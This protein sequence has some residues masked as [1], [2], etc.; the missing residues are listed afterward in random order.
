MEKLINDL[1]G[2]FIVIGVISVLIDF[3]KSGLFLIK[4]S[5]NSKLIQRFGQLFQIMLSGIGYLFLVVV[6]H[7][8]FW[9][10]S[11]L[12]NETLPAIVNLIFAIGYFLFCISSIVG[13]MRW[14][15]KIITP[16]I[17]GS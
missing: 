15:K 9:L 17:D 16:L 4:R 11:V 1:T 10:F 12:F 3:G 2:L 5:R 6:G 8:S 13:R 7:L 14:F